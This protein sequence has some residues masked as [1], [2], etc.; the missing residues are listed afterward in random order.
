MCN[1]RVLEPLLPCTASKWFVGHVGEGQITLTQRRR[2][3]CLVGREE[4]E[5]GKE[6]E[7]RF[8]LVAARRY[9]GLSF[10]GLSGRI[11]HHRTVG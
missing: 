6:G 4:E 10:P 11:L 7:L 5:G 9:Q 2:G 3:R 8:R 1:D